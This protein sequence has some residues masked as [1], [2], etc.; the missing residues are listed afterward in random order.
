MKITV[1]TSNQPRHISLIESLASISDEVF[2]IQE[3]N[4][5]FPGRV[6]DFFQKSEVMQEY[7]GNVITAERKVFGDLKFTSK[8]VSQLV[9]KNGDLNMMD[10]TTLSPALHSDYY[11]VFGSSYIKGSLIDFLIEKKAINIHMGVSPFYRGSSCNFWALFD[12][13]IEYIGATIH[14]LSRGL[15]SGDMLFHA[16]PKAESTDPFVLGM[17]AVRSAHNS[18]IEYIKT[19]RINELTPL[20]QNKSQEIRYTRN[21]DFTDEVARHY[22]KNTPSKAEIKSKLEKRVLQKFLNPFIG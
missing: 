21:R 6:N 12:G 10:L 3:C 8:N 7:F 16:L 4:T 15:D 20:K 14:R 1:F 18:L 17:N 19:G 22:L 2:A 5:I 11:V 13:N 9:I